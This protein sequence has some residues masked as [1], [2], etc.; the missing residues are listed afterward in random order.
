VRLAGCRSALPGMASGEVWTC[1]AIRATSVES[2]GSV[3]DCKLHT[4]PSSMPLSSA[5]ASCLA[6][7]RC[8]ARSRTARRGPACLRVGSLRVMIAVP[9]RGG[10]GSGDRRARRSAWRGCLSPPATEALSFGGERVGVAYAG[11]LGGGIELEADSIEHRADEDIGAV[12]VVDS[13]FSTSVP[14]GSRPENVACSISPG[15]ARSLRSLFRS[16]APSARC[17]GVRG[18]NGT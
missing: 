14:A 17:S 7:R 11:R 6:G 1:S 18:S 2:T 5:A 9:T 8:R 4:T 15:P 12:E 3:W 13:T 10:R 16:S